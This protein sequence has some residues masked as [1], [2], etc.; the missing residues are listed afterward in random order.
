M[1]T[2]ETEVWPNAPLALVAVEARFPEATSGPLR[3]P[4]QR[5]LRDVLGGDWVL[6]GV[7]QET[8]Q[9]AVG[10][11][12]VLPQAVKVENLTRLTIRDRTQAITVRPDSVTIEAARYPGY[13]EFREV[14]RAAFDAVERVLEPDG[15]TRLGVR[16]IDEIR[17]PDSGDLGL[18]DGWINSALLA[19]RAEG[20][21]VKGWT[22]AVQ[23]ETGEDRRLVL[24]Y[25]PT[26]GPVVDPSGP[27]RRPQPPPPGGAFVLDFDSFWH[28]SGIPTFSSEDLLNA[29]DGLRD[30]VRR[31]FDQLISQRLIDEVFR[32]ESAR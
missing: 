28:P 10:A 12:G 17:V 24:R 30:P 29:C 8:M 21:T 6:E 20:L 16:Y 5:A 25:G 11:S 1:S 22:S 2:K 13:R 14:L 9:I 23:Y 15:M 31:L 27:L 3:P 19:P 18:W 26:E 7:K 32:K 4:V